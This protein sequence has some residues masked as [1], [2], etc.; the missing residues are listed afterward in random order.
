MSHAPTRPSTRRTSDHVTELD[1]SVPRAAHVARTDTTSLLPGEL[2][3]LPTAYTV[4]RVDL[5]RAVALDRTGAPRAGD[6]V[7]AE[8][9]TLG[10]HARLENAH[11]RRE[12]L[13][14]GSRIVVAFG[15]RYASDQFEAVVPDGLGLCEL[16]AG[17]GLAARVRSKHDRAREATRIVPLGMLVDAEGHRLS[18]A[19]GAREHLPV[20]S[21]GSGPL[22]LVVAGAAMNAGKTTTVATACRG[23]AAAG[24]RVGAAK[25][26]GTGSGNDVWSFHDGGARPVMDFTDLGHPSTWGV[27]VDELA[28]MLEQSIA[29]LAHA[30]CEVAVIE[31]ADGLLQA[32]T[33]ALLQHRVLRERCDG[34]L[35][36]AT[37]A[38]CG[39]AG[40]RWLRDRDLD[41]LAVTGV[42]SSSPLAIRELE[43]EAGVTVWT[44][45]TLADAEAAASLVA[46]LRARR[47]SRA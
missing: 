40:V 36:A 46:T 45:S 26:T 5:D 37:D 33:A 14:V 39:V 35:F 9:A 10:H 3:D 38:L 11:G 29:H 8:V 13:V 42:V 20:P 7:L 32:D 24:Y 30:G 34:L 16:V 47:G 18:V 15:A 21:H 17:G 19:D 25:V 22:V 28:S 44:T 6:V 4:R 12:T 43:A 23:L 31:V 41:P 1:P 27:P 2:A